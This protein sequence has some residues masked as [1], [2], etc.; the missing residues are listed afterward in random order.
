MAEAVVGVDVGGTFTDLV[1]FGA[2]GTISLGK[3]PSTPED[4]A[5]GIMAGLRAIAPRMRE[6]QRIAHGTTVSTN[7]LLQGKGG[8]VGMLTTSGF[9]DALEI[10]RTRRMLPSLYDPE[11]VR[12]APLVPRP[13]R[14]EVDERLASDGS[15]LRA[16]ND[17]DVVDAATRLGGSVESIAVCFLHSWAN[18][19]H[20]R[21]AAELIRSALPGVHVTTSSDVIPEFREYERFSTTA[22]NAFLLPVMDRYLASLDKALEDAGCAGKLSTMSSAGGTLDVLGARRLPVRTILSGPAG[23]V[24]GALWVA[25]AAGLDRFITCDMGG[26]S[27]DVCVVEDGRPAFVSETAFAGLPLKGLQ[28][29]INTVGAGGG[30]V[31]YAEADGILHVGPRSAGADPGPAAYGRGGNEPTVTD[32]NLVL[33]R[34][35]TERPLGGSVRL[36]RARA[37]A[38]IATLASSLAMDAEEL[39]EGILRLAVA[40]MAGAIRAI[41]IERGRDPTD[42]AL[43]PFGGAGGMHA[44]DLAEELGIREILVPTAPGNL[45]ALGLLTCDQRQELVRTWVRPLAN[46]SAADVRDLLGAQERS[47]RSLQMLADFP[48]ERVR[49]EHALE[50]RYARQAFEIAVRL[51]DAAVTPERLRELFL[52]EYRRLYGHADEGGAIE[53]V[54]L[55]TVAIGVTEKPVPHRLPAP[56]KRYEAIGKRSVRLNGTRFD[57]PLYE[58]GSFGP[59][60]AFEGPAI[61]EEANATTVVLPHWRGTVDEFGNLRLRR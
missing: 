2:D 54:T 25:N 3:V 12:P 11:F 13:L 38:A 59:G 7:A 39:A 31:A 28:Y 61:V 21:R 45:S 23:G 26:T 18:P 9:R 35:G 60:D 19:Q 47:G 22:I 8:T 48:A 34:L 56:A 30:S 57:V 53:I 40:R 5:V 4:Q 33:G 41:T 6:L 15:V 17:G 36:D 16:L 14:C 49:F 20:E 58:R 27:T 46:V 55:R 10:G 52:E 24:A 50:M 44:C 29:D 51:P 1:L 42:Y 37:D 43:F 32:A